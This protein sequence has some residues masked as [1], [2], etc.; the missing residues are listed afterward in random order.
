MQLSH[1]LQPAHL[2]HH[3]CA[4]L[5][6]GSRLPLP[7]LLLPLGCLL[8]SFLFCARLSGGSAVRGIQEY[9]NC[10]LKRASSHKSSACQRILGTYCTMDEGLTAVPRRAAAMRALDHALKHAA[11]GCVP[12][13]HC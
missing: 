7:L 6:P 2:V 5:L 12:Q 3:D 9:A 10:S 11:M 8:L 1:S 13:L 4:P